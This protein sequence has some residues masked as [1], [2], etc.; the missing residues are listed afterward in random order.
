MLNLGGVANVTWIGE[1]GAVLAF[2]TGPGNAPIDDWLSRHTGRAM[3]TDGRVAR[4]GRVDN[5]LLARLLAHPYFTRPPPKSLDRDDFGWRLVERLALADGAA[6]LTAFAAEAV[7]AG[8]RHFPMAARRWLVSGG[9]RHNGAL[10]AAL[11]AA[12]TTPV[13]PVEA[14]GWQGDALEAQAFAWL[15]VRSRLGLPLSLP[16]TTGVR[17]ALSGGRFHSAS[18]GQG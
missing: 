16:S 5:E 8:A 12:L 11:A 3:D 2:D 17:R 4:A 10:M 13:E 18:E 6:T 1:D 15:A 9:G 7:A 14:V